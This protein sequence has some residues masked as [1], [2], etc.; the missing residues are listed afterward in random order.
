MPSDPELTDAA[1]LLDLSAA[2]AAP[3]PPPRPT[4]GTRVAALFEVIACSDYPT[5]LLIAALLLMAGYSPIGA[6]GQL[7]LGYVFALSIIDAAVLIGLIV[8]FL[9]IHG[10]RPREVLLGSRPVG[11]EATLGVALIPVAI[12]IGVGLLFAIQELAP[13]LHNV[14]QN[15][16]EGLI[17]TPGDAALFAVLTLVAGGFREEIQRA[18]ILR[19]F[20]QSLGGPVVGIIVSSIGFGAGHFL[21]GWDA[22]ITTGVLGA[23]WGVIYLR[24]RSIA[25]NVVSHAGFDLVEIVQYVVLH[26]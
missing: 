22:V 7:R 5:Q 11:R 14:A 4:A 13:K 12:A 9:W 26:H 21:Q 10:E 3:V 15:P 25:A 23:F 1:E 6:D 16:L 20:E 24:R 2:A 19:R 18:F 8:F 17:R